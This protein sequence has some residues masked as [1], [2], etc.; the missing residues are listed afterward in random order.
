MKKN[1]IIPESYSQ[2]VNCKMGICEVG[3][4]QSNLGLELIEGGDGDPI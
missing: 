3:S 1:Y 4:V 2:Q